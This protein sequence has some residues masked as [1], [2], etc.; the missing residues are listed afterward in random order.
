LVC[1]HVMVVVVVD[2]V[3]MVAGA[4]LMRRVL[5]LLA[6]TGGRCGRL[7]AGAVCPCLMVAAVVAR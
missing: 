2:M 3:G 1:R 4:G 5:V 7:A 6:T